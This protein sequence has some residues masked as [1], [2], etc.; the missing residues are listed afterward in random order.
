VA[1]F[2]TPQM[3]WLPA[4]AGV[5]N[6]TQNG[7]SKFW[8][9]RTVA[10]L[11]TET[12]CRMGQGRVLSQGWPIAGPLM[13]NHSYLADGVKILSSPKWGDF[14]WTFEVLSWFGIRSKGLKVIEP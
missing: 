5:S 13:G 10:W 3:C 1:D 7:G 8:T 12:C 6:G 4:K 14:P 9:F 2:L 11:L